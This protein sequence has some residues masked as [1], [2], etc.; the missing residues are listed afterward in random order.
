M[1]TR[2]VD[3]DDGTFANPCPHGTPHDPP[4]DPGDDFHEENVDQ[5]IQSLQNQSS[6][7]PL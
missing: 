7:G 2:G 4:I 5:S 6:E 3:N 1:N